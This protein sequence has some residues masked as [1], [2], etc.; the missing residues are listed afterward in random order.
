MI[1]VCPLWVLTAA[2]WWAADLP[3]WW[4]PE[5]SVGLLVYSV[6]GAFTVLAR[7]RTS[8]RPGAPI[9]AE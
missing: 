8:V 9:D 1:L 6:L 2:V 4:G 3:N 7:F 5:P